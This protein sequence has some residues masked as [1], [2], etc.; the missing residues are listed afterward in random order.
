MLVPRWNCS[1]PGMLPRTT[2]F[3]LRSSAKTAWTA[4]C[5]IDQKSNANFLQWKKKR[6]YNIPNNNMVCFTVC[7]FYQLNDLNDD[8]EFSVQFTK[9]SWGLGFTISSYIGDLNS[10]NHL[11]Q[12]WTRTSKPSIFQA[13]LAETNFEQSDE[14]YPLNVSNWWWCRVSTNRSLHKQ[15]YVLLWIDLALPS[16][17]R[18]CGSEEHRERQ[19][20]G[21]RWTH[22]PRWHRPL[23]EFLFWV[24][25]PS[26][27]KY[28]VVW[29]IFSA[30]C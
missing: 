25:V 18:R 13:K 4:R 15:R 6:K 3:H 8:Y 14:W 28:L 24:I 16:L 5:E 23:C 9:N 29:N 27:D 1:S 20:R 19:H 10:G 12:V 2:T 7:A 22:Q 21:P 17:Q 26:E 11:Y 30:E